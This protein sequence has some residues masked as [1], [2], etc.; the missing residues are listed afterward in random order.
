[1]KRVQKTVLQAVAS[2]ASHSTPRPACHT[3]KT[4]TLSAQ[5]NQAE[6]GGK[7]TRQAVEK[8]GS[9]IVFFFVESDEKSSENI[10]INDRCPPGA[11]ENYG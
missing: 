1:M 4:V 5:Q 2:Q 3:A 7:H 9:S 11:V 10:F 8:V 6:N